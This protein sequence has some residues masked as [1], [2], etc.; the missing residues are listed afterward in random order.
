MGNHFT[1]RSF[2]MP[3][4]DHISVGK[5]LRA[6]GLN[7]QLKVE[8]FSDFPGRFVTGQEFYIGATKFQCKYVH[9]RSGTFILKLDGIETKEEAN[10]VRGSLLTIPQSEAPDLPEGTFYYHEVEDLEVWTDEDIYLGK[11]TEIINTASNDVY[12]VKNIDQ[13]ILIPATS[14]VIKLIN[15]KTQRLTIHVIPGL[16][17]NSF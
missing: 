7:G 14:D 17:K 8:P 13:E 15:L 5:I 11:I 6:W 2:Q 9:Q 1:P 3:P 4:P 12:V 10:K 16:F